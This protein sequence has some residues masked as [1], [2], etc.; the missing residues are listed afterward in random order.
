MNANA[1]P[2]TRKI[3]LH[4]GMQF[5]L[6]SGVYSP[7]TLFALTG[8]CS[9]MLG[10]KPVHCAG[11]LPG[12]SLLVHVLQPADLDGL[13]AQMRSLWSKAQLPIK[14]WIEFAERL[15]C[16][17]VP[18]DGAR[19]TLALDRLLTLEKGVVQFDASLRH[20]ANISD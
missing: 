9:S 4:E 14:D 7:H 1:D 11:F 6:D 8:A 3:R 16:L 17:R 12:V 5:K 18:V 13:D 19:I 15:P 2:V 20:A 10:G